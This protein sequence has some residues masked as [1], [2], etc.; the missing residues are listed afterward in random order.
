VPSA[1]GERIRRNR[2]DP[3]LGQEWPVIVAPFCARK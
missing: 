1:G 3:A 2:I